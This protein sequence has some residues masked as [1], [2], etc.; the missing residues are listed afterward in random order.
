VGQPILAAA[1]FPGG[2][3]PD[4]LKG[5]AF[6]L[7]VL[8]AAAAG[9]HGATFYHDVLPIIEQ[10]CQSCH[11][12]GEIAPMPFIT[13]RDTRPWAKAIREAVLTRKMPPWFADPAHGRFANDRSLTPA[14]IATLVS[15]VDAGAPEGNRQARHTPKQWVGGWNINPPDVVLGM[16][17]PFPVPAAGAVNYQFVI[18]PTGFTQDTWIQMA[19]VRPSDRRVV[20]HAVVYVREPGSEWLKGMP[21]GAPFDSRHTRVSTTSDILAIYTPGSEPQRWK[22]SMGKLVKA[23]S[24]LV[25]QIHYTGVGKPVADQT[26]IGLVFAREPV[27]ERVH[28]LQMSDEEFTIPAGHPNFP[29]VVRGTMPNRARLLSFLP[30]MH[31]RGASFEYKMQEPD[32]TWRTLLR[33]K[34]YNFYWQLSYELAEPIELEAGTKLECIG[35]FDNSR[36]NPNNP[37]P[38]AT[39]HVGE[40]SWDEMMVGF[41]DVAVDASVDKQH[42]WH[43]PSACAARPEGLCHGS[44]SSATRFSNDLD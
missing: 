22:P 9:A 3:L 44:A 23:G 39:V 30:H 27:R 17:Q 37:D 20:H 10:H 7:C 19:E 15:W 34:P 38:E 16:P 32:G 41:F 1:A 21:A 24:D 36:R 12:P 2:V 29:V 31:L 18:V 28:T 25:F 26:R 33:V 8:L 4:R 14:E 11:R 5:L 42:L 43:R 13:Y 6:R 35:W 40:Q